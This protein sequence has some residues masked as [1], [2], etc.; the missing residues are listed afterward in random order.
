MNRS[1]MNDIEQDA[2]IGRIKFIIKSLGLSQAQFASKLGIDPGNISKHLNGRLPVT[3]GLVN[4]IAV[5]MGISKRWLTDGV[6]VP[7]PK[8]NPEMSRND[9]LQALSVDCVSGT[10]VYDIDVTAGS[11][12]L[13]REFTSDR[14]IGFVNIPEVRPGTAIVRVNGDSMTPT[15]SD[16]AFVAIRPVSDLSC[17][18]WGQIYVVV[19]DDF[20]MV[21]HIRRHENPEK[22]ILR[23]DN[24]MY[25]DM[26]IDRDKIRKLYV[27]ESILNVRI[28]C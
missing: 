11:L 22:V 25:D 12:E 3:Q 10:P 26:E 14:V 19:L 18:F 28:Q 16:G 2:V 1:A 17:I 20:R 4:R 5:D 6:G 8:G 21:K 9:G 24:P 7:F 27:V 23:S 13:S 15:I